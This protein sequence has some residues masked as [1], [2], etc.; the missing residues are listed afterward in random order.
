MAVDFFIADELRLAV[1]DGVLV[2][3]S[4]AQDELRRKTGL[5]VDAYAT[6]VVSSEHARLWCDGLERIAPSLSA[7]PEAQRACGA[8][9]ALLAEAAMR[10]VT[11]RVEGE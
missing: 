9:A 4:H 5:V 3:L 2:R 7:D 6:S 11:V 10:K 8:L 1:P